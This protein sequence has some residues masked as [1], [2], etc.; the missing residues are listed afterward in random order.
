M[1]QASANGV[2]L[3]YQAFGD[4]A[5]EPL[6]LIMGL[7]AQMTA[8]PEPFCRA[9]A[10]AGFHVV[11]FDNRDIGLSTIRDA[12]VP[13]LGAL[14]GGD[15]SVLPYTMS[16]LA[17]DVVGLLDALG[18]PAAHVVG[19]SMGGMIGQQL[20]IDHPE[21][22]RSLCSIMST[23]G[24]HEVGQPAS[25]VLPL[26][27]APAARNREEAI[28]RGQ[29]LFETVGSPAYPTSTEDLRA[30]LGDA[31][32][33]SYTPAGTARQLACIIAAP[34]RTAALG[35]VTVPAAVVHGDADKLVDVS[36]G[37]AT[38][39]ALGVTPLIIEGAG[40]DLPEAL[41]ETYVGAI[42]ENARRAG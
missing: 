42:V 41:W 34:D 16:D 11:R 10:D 12:P 17:D 26:V 30:Q 3:E 36:G 29:K 13:D 6:L 19:A 4:P 24:S 28:D 7:G 9:V 38:A 25:E 23:T 2:Q 14:L 8:W 32:D 20:V 37:Y 27:F 15:L 21:R 33:R 35:S 18:L 39:A 40:H 1:A 31:Y 22:V 5:A